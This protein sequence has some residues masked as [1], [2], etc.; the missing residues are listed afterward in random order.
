M[1]AETVVAALSALAHETRLAAFRHLVVC[2]PHGA[3]AGRIAERLGLPAATLSFH[4]KE[5]RS[6]GLVTCDRHGRS[7]IYRTDC[8]RMEELVGFLTR[9]CC[10]GES[11]LAQEERVP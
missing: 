5:L 6:A 4:L 9:N 3:P 2:G 7:V 1:E 11:A 8:A 10:Q